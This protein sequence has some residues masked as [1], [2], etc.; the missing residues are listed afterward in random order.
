M[1]NLKSIQIP[2][3]PDFSITPSQYLVFRKI[4][5]Q[6]MST[7]V[8]NYKVTPHFSDDETG[9]KLSSYTRV[10]MVLYFKIWVNTAKVASHTVKLKVNNHTIITNNFQL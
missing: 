8:Y 9:K 4:P 3:I 6:N 7:F 2:Y 10:N 1:V 5:T